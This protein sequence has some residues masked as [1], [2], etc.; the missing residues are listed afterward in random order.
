MWGE[1]LET[2][3]PWLVRIGGFLSEL[4]RIPQSRRDGSERFHRSGEDL[5]FDLLGFWKWSVSD[6]VSNATRGRLA[7]YIIAQAIGAAGGVRD[8]W[9]AYDLHDP[10]GIAIEVKSAAYI[11]SWHQDRLSTISFNC[12]KSR[13]WNPETNRQSNVQTR[14][15]QVYV[16]ALLA[17]Q[18]QSTLDPFDVAQWEFYVVPTFVLDERKRSQH[19]I[20][21]TS[22]RALH[23]PPVAYSEL[24][25]AVGVAAETHRSARSC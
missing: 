21:L 23:G 9:A 17:H 18:D 19:S 7:E 25:S 4:G 15:A 1:V 10:R 20:T 22:L 6:V 14:Q 2:A 5:G 24:R 16:F 8:E 12:P 3:E 13:A 11:Q